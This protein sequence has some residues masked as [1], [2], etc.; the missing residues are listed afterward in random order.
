[1][2][3]AQ[4]TWDPVLAVRVYNSI[5]KT[6]IIMEPYKNESKKLV[7]SC[8]LSEG[9]CRL[10]AKGEDSPGAQV[11]SRI[12]DKAVEMRDKAK[13]YLFSH[14]DTPGRPINVRIMPTSSSNV[15]S[16]MPEILQS[17]L[18]SF[19]NPFQPFHGILIVLRFM[20]R[21]FHLIL[22]L[23]MKKFRIGKL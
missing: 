23:F 22:I 4:F 14:S 2:A 1:M 6:K 7:S 9:K 18:L 20:K 15:N 12:G 19:I 11:G 16:L 8:G 3:I 17:K 13:A 10:G 5:L 21:L